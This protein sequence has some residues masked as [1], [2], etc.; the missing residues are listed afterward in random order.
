MKPLRVLPPNF[1]RRTS[2][3]LATFFSEKRNEL[4]LLGVQKALARWSN[5]R[6]LRLERELKEERRNILLQEELLWL[7]KSR[8]DW[9]KSGDNNTTYFH[10]AT[11]VRRRRN[12]IEALINDEG[13][14]IQD[15]AKLKEMAMEFYTQLSRQNTW[16][17]LA[18][19]QGVFCESVRR[20][21][22]LWQPTST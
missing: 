1:M 3:R 6:L 22:R 17:G 16:S 14:W 8:Q 7:Q 18:S 15:K 9:L 10:T 12:R 2:P 11:L 19:S 4:R 20:T 13:S 5:S 21:Y